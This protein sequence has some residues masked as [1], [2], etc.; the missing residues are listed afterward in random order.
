VE[1]GGSE[2]LN[3]R[4]EPAIQ[5]LL[6]DY[7][8]RVDYRDESPPEDLFTADCQF[9]LGTLILR[10]RPMLAEFFR[11]RRADHIAS[12]RTTRHFST[13]FRARTVGTNRVSASSTV[14]AIAGFGP[15]P[16]ESALPSVADFDD[17]CV[18]QADGCWLFESRTATSIFAG[19]NAP[20]FARTSPSTPAAKTEI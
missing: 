13:N 10:G 8:L 3:L 18:M 16:I 1:C 15:W 4:W 20:G 7:W 17:I 11:Q 12:S 14:F 9:A 5:K 19:P 6:T 2:A